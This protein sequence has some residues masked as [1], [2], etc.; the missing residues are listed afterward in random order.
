MFLGAKVSCFFHFHN[1]SGML[2]AY[3]KCGILLKIVIDHRGYAGVRPYI[4]CR[5]H[6]VY[7]RIDRQDDTQDGD[8]GAYA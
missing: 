4:L 6:H 1:T 7:N 5:F 3:H 8:R 2:F